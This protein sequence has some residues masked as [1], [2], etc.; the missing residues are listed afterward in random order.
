MEPD[1]RRWSAYQTLTG[2]VVGMLVAGLVVPMLVDNPSDSSGVQ[3]GAASRR[4]GAGTDTGSASGDIT[5]AAATTV[6]GSDLASGSTGGIG[7]AAGTTATGG[8]GAVTATDSSPIKLGFSLFD[9]AGASK[10]GFAIGVSPD[11][12]KQAWQA[13]VDYVNGTGGLNGRKIVPSYSTYDLTSADS[14][15]ASCLALT[16]DDHVFAVMG[17]YNFPAANVC[18]VDANRTLLFNVLPFT[19]DEAYRSGRHVSI[20]MKASRLMATFARR[21][22]EQGLLKGKRIGILDDLGG[23]PTE[24]VLGALRAEVKARGGNIVHESVLS[25]DLGA[26]SSRVPVEVSQ[27]H[28]A[29][30]DLVLLLSTP[31]FGTQF[32]HEAESQQWRPVY[33]GSDFNVWY[34]DVGTQNMPSSFDGSYSF[35]TARVGDYKAGLPESPQALRCKAI[36]EQMTHTKAPAY[37][38]DFSGFIGTACDAVLTFAS[39]ARGA[40]PTLDQASFIAA[41]QRLGSLDLAA[42]GGGSFGPGKLDLNDRTR[43]LRWFAACKC[44]KPTTPFEDR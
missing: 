31:I 2:V 21:L 33:A 5:G 40:G 28:T 18:V 14:E 36:F 44:W 15:Q 13:F 10:V 42:W 27:M 30:V 19:I 41:T 23:D 38:Q 8:A 9:V 29:K 6:V 34:T 37:G 3:A 25:A 24:S 32:A 43:I 16:Q 12:E 26:G 20:F 39:A 7:G 1:R 22:D 17:G 4:A 11:Q 35:S